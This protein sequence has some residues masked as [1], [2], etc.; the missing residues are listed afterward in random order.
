MAR[1]TLKSADAEYERTLN[2]LTGNDFED[3]V[4]ALLQKT[5]I[6]FQP[7]PAN[8]GDGGLDGLSHQQTRAYCMYGPKAETARRKE[9]PKQLERDIVAKFKKDLQRL[10]ELSGR[11]GKH[12]ENAELPK[13]LAVDKKIEHI[14]L[15]TN[16]F[17]GPK[18]IGDLNTARNQFAQQSKCNFVRPEA[19][20]VIWGPK[21]LCAQT[22][23]DEHILYRA[24]NRQINKHLQEAI[25]NAADSDPVSQ[26]FDEKF[27]YLV[28]RGKLKRQSVNELQNILLKAWTRS[29]VLDRELSNTSPNLHRELERVREAAVL[30]AHLEKADA[31]TAISSLRDSIFRR[32]MDSLSPP[33]D[34]GILIDAAAG[35]TSRLIGVC[36][37]D[38]R[39]G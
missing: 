3:E 12:K 22:T 11:N 18:I 20:L 37:L 8:P 1:T 35:E 30:D 29:I 4:C 9:L 17:D 16:N 27:A 7:V 23:I 31:R 15:I 5:F 10:F 36:P 38:W 6:D 21:Q 25:D 34:S 14:T 33:L 19:T 24:G 2:L 32:L 39:E 28:A 26:T 13:I